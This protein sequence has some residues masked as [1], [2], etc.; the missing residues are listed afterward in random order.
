[1]KRG[2]TK[3]SLC[4]SALSACLALAGGA[5]AQEPPSP[6]AHPASELTLAGLR[7]GKDTFSA[8]EK[9]FKSRLLRS[10]DTTDDGKDKSDDAAPRG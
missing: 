4:A 7:P 6:K 10:S 2:W 8:A 5:R 9:R 3:F 1:M